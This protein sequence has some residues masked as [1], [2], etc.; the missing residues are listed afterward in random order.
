MT[1]YVTYM[2][3]NTPV[4][5]IVIWTNL[6]TA[7][8]TRTVCYELADLENCIALHQ[9]DE[10]LHSKSNVLM[11]IFDSNNLPLNADD[12]VNEKEFW[13]QVEVIEQQVLAQ[14]V[15]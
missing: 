3:S 9:L 1:N 13:R 14:Q 5:A 10:G 11:N 6:E 8:Q 2:S 12:S 4:Y 15:A 7:Y